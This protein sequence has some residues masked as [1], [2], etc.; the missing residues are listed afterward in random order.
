MSLGYTIATVA[1]SR[2]TTVAMLVV[3]IAMVLFDFKVVR[4]EI[5]KNSQELD[6]GEVKDYKSFNKKMYVLEE[7]IFLKIG[8]GL[9]FIAI[10]NI[11][12]LVRYG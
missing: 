6:A 10:L 9:I 8:A 5:K 3:G 2:T 7:R 4:K 11:I 1:Y 12:Q